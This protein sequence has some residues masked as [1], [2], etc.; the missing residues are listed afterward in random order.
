MKRINIYSIK[1]VKES[2]GLYDV[3][4]TRLSSPEIVA[5]IIEKVFSLS[6]EA[7]EVFGVLTLTTKNKIAGAHIISRGTLNT[8]LVHPREV[9]KPA[10]LNNAAAVIIFHNHPSGDTTP[11]QED[12][13]ITH[14]LVEAG[15]LLGISVL[16]HLIIGE[17]GQ[18]TSFCAGG[19]LRS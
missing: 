17:G 11:S 2:S 9:F 18:F 5:E 1:Q 19:I 6:E 16:D 7:V 8:S 4:S 14:K 15:K 13:V 12:R 10:I 3:D